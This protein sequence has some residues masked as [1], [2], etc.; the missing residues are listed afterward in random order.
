[1][2][3]IGRLYTCGIWRAKPGREDE[4]IE[5]W[6]AFAAW[7]AAHQPGAE[8]AIL[9]QDADNARTFLSFSPWESANHVAE[10][11]SRPE[12]QAFVAQV[13]ELCEEFRPHTMMLVGDSD[14]PDEA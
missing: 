7:T 14:L 11:R 13:R 10:W 6:Q 8:R 4:L 9:L 3:E 12:F 1:M 5:T 2:S